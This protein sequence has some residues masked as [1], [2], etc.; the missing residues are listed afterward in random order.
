M[1]VQS[2]IT[3]T[4]IVKLVA[5]IEAGIRAGTLQAGERLP[6]IRQV[7]QHL[8][9][10]PATVAA[11]FRRL[12][13]RGLLVTQGRGG[14]RVSH[15]P[16]VSVGRTMD[17]PDGV[18][19]CAAGNPDRR[20]L[21]K[22]GPALAAVRRTQTLYDEDPY[23]P[24]LVT[25]GRS[26][27]QRDGLEVERICVT[28]GSLDGIERVLAETVY[29]G[30]RVAVEDPCFNGVLD[31]VRA[32]GLVPV[33]VAVDE[34]GIR[35]D[36][37]TQALKQKPGALIVTPR[38][39]NPTGAAFTEQRVCELEVV[40]ESAP[41]M[42]VIEDD[43]V[44][45]LSGVD[46][47]G[48]CGGTRRRWAVVRSLCKAYGPDLRIALLAGDEEIQARIQG[49]QVLG[50]RWVSHLLQDMAVHFLQDAETQATLVRARER[51]E[52]RRV[53]LI[54]ALDTHGIPAVGRSGFNVWVPVMEEASV[55]QGLLQS[56]WLVTPGERYRLQSGPAIRITTAALAERQAVA[57]ARDLRDC[58]RGGSVRGGAV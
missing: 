27:F 51:Y 15:R 57:L 43:Y 53:A 14:T 56:G 3:G 41:E 26:G 25:L 52:G 21:P 22:L 19:D 42:M 30:D 8:D 16:P 10:S 34:N 49:R 13:E 31:L 2:C 55:A 6:S 48:L 45:D 46:Y 28:N 36:A 54:R 38:A 11:A 12:Q 20:L 33:P 9:I 5:S 24:E 7:A 35:P 47:V 39:H 23:H 40:L 1:A 29:P 18:V 17:T 4:S 50:I 37:L 32:R 44:G 58:L